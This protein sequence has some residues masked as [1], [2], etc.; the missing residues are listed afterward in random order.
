MRSGGI[1]AILASM[2]LAL[3]VFGCASTPK[4]VPSPAVQE[5]HSA[6]AQSFAASE[7]GRGL[8]CVGSS[9]QKGPDGTPIPMV[10]Y[11]DTDGAET[12][13]LIDLARQNDKQKIRLVVESASAASQT[14][15]VA[16]Q[17]ATD[18][19]SSHASADDMPIEFAPRA[20]V[21]TTM[22]EHSSEASSD[23]NEFNPIE[24]MGGSVPP[25]AT[26][27]PDIPAPD[28]SKKS[29]KGAKNKKSKAEPKVVEEAPA[30][31]AFDSS[32][33]IRDTSGGLP[34]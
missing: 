1:A 14:S 10:I 24:L 12:A 33:R 27:V 20:N 2:T 9:A 4:N 18:S 17:H 15:A 22:T 28:D 8:V 26:V 21:S 7:Y 34:F 30:R 13:R 6:G 29:K 31:P 5:Q 16:V 19:S 3:S 25:V 32:G 11:L 23:S